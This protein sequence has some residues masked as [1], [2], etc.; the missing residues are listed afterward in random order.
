MEAHENCKLEG[1]ASLGILTPR[2]EITSRQ[3]EV[4]PP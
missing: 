3:I 1:K 4:I 2:R